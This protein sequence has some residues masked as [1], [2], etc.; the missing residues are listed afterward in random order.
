MPYRKRTLR[1]MTHDQK[2]VA[3]GLLPSEQA[4][5]ALKQAVVLEKRSYFSGHITF[6]SSDF[7]QSG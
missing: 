2:I 4:T 7:F 1:N 6:F 3:R 5:K